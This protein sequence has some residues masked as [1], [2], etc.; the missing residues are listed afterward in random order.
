MRGAPNE[1]LLRDQFSNFAYNCIIYHDCVR[2][3]GSCGLIG[4]QACND[5]Y[6]AASPPPI[7]SLERNKAT[8]PPAALRLPSPICLDVSMLILHDAGELAAGLLLPS[9]VLVQV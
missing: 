6:L 2:R 7:G 3:A 9:L 4:Q 5:L 1:A 8:E